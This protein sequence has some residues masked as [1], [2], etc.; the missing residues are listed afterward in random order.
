MKLLLKVMGSSFGKVLA[1]QVLRPELDPLTPLLGKACAS[2]KGCGL[3]VLG[4][5]HFLKSYLSR[6]N[7]LL[8]LTPPVPQSPHL[9]LWPLLAEEF[10]F[11]FSFSR[12]GLM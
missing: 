7:C 12:Q 5:H 2:Y 6:F 3:P 10:L 11:T 4:F 1:A 9:I 8:H